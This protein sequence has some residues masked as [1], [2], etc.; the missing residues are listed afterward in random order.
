MTL[1]V[2]VA[3]NADLGFTEK[4]DAVA[5]AARARC[6][7]LTAGDDPE[8][9]HRLV[10]DLAYTTPMPDGCQA[11]AGLRA[12]L[13][14]EL[15]AVEHHMAAT[16]G[17]GG[18]KEPEGIEVVIV[19]VEKGSTPTADLAEA[20]TRA[21]RLALQSRAH[22]GVSGVTVTVHDACVLP[23]LL[24]EPNYAQLD[25]VIG[26]HTGH[27]VV[28]LGGG[29]TSVTVT[30]AAVA[31]T[32]HP[33]SWSVILIDRAPA[34]DS[35][36]SGSPAAADPGRAHP[37]PPV[38]DMSLE[39]DPISGWLMGLGLPTV[40]EA[41]KD[42]RN[43]PVD[44][45]VRNVAAAI[46]RALG[47]GPQHRAAS[48]ADVSTLLAADVS[49][50]DLAA[51]MTLRMW[52]VANY[53]DLH[54][55]MPDHK[56][57]TKNGKNQLGRVLE[58]AKKL[59]E[60]R[61]A[62]EDWLIRHAH[63]KD[64]GVQATHRLASGRGAGGPRELHDQVQEALGCRIPDWLSWPG[65]DV[66]L[67]NAQ[68]LDGNRSRPGDPNPPKLRAPLA[69]NLLAQPPAD[70]L[71]E[72]CSVSGPLRLSVLTAY[73]PDT[74][75]AACSLCQGLRHGGDGTQD[76]PSRSSDWDL[77]DAETC[78]YSTSMTESGV[79]S[80]D[81]QRTMTA[82]RD[83]AL[84]W[85]E[86]RTPRPR[87]ITVGTTGQKGAVIA[88]LQAAQ[89]YGA[90]HGV[91]VFLLSSVKDFPTG[92]EHFQFH[93]FGLDR[94]VR[95]AL[96]EAASHCLDRLD[97]LTVA[98]LLNLGGPE[99]KALAARAS[100]LADELVDAVNSLNLDQDAPVVLSV[101]EAIAAAIHD[102]VP[103]D[104]EVRLATIAGELVRPARPSDAQKQQG[105]TVTAAT[106]MAMRGSIKDVAGGVAVVDL[107][108]A[109]LLRL[110]Y[111]I[112]NETPV[113][114]GASGLADATRS[115]LRK[116]HL[117]EAT[118]YPQLV[119]RTVE[120]VHSA[121]PDIAHSDWHDRLTGLR[122]E[123]N[124]LRSGAAQTQRKIYP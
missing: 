70:E 69:V 67:L 6:G 58:K 49:R 120:T 101:L 60:P 4:A 102:G 103:P 117:D 29:A 36:T 37:V 111:A 77:G 89:A 59:D 61:P 115:V 72:A 22:S 104:A 15:A 57:L 121:H 123:I 109:D 93:Q 51:G 28:P 12:P 33:D 66:C 63:L 92:A 91:P 64:P 113:N 86:S 76:W 85:L 118:T 96:L 44:C 99:M 27:V 110:V 119:L 46:R 80:D 112:R 40:L 95:D 45:V 32:T 53:L 97:L 108:A 47:E 31:A 14:R 1:L 83:D 23:D 114:H 35:Q 74:H 13:A 79:G 50:G 55:T 88:L 94:D 42:A 71:R 78:G 18:K 68:G 26:E 48:V 116:C 65:P 87:A 41:V 11:T 54:R 24:E 8:T 20:L 56:D 17:R 124:T 9:A 25:G 122:G 3:G 5:D 105:V 2:H 107:E 81:I 16:Q 30:V 7:E 34:P 39:G 62:P 75:N 82:L 38:L 73:S 84:G 106:I 21:L 43:E 100:S 10:L 52:L 19:G 90:G 98:R